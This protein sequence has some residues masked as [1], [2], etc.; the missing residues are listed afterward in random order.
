M[1]REMKTYLGV[2]FPLGWAPMSPAS[3]TQAWAP[4][5]FPQ[6]V[7]FIK[8]L[9]NFTKVLNLVTFIKALLFSFWSTPWS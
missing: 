7:I 5:L 4:R 3:F 9:V 2:P 8:A 6:L 1:N